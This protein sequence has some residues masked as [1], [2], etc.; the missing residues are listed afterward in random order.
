[1]AISAGFVRN[2]A[3][4]TIL[5]L[6]MEGD[7]YPY[8]ILQD[9]ET[10]FDGQYV[11]KRATLYDMLKR[12]EKKG[13]VSSYF[14][15]ETGGGRRSYYKIEPAGIE[16]LE[17]AKSEYR[18]MNE[19]IRDNSDDLTPSNLVLD[20]NY[21]NYLAQQNAKSALQSETQ[22]DAKISTANHN[23]MAE[24]PK[25]EH[26]LFDPSMYT[27]TEEPIQTEQNNTTT[28]FDLSS[29]EDRDAVN[30]LLADIKEGKRISIITND[31]TEAV[32][33]QLDNEDCDNSIDTQNQEPI[34]DIQQETLIE[35]VPFVEKT[36][37]VNEIIAEEVINYTQPSVSLE[38]EQEATATQ[39]EEVACA[40]TLEAETA[41][42]AEETSNNT[43]INVERVLAEKEIIAQKFQDTLRIF[44]VQEDWHYNIEKGV[45]EAPTP[46]LPPE[47]EDISTLQDTNAEQ[48]ESTQADSEPIQNA[49]NASFNINEDHDAQFK[50]KTY[51]KAQPME[52]L[53]QNMLRE[54]Y[55]IR[56]YNSATMNHNEPKN[57]LIVK[58]LRDSSLLTFLF[59]VIESIL[60]YILRDYFAYDIATLV[61]IVFTSLTIPAVFAFIGLAYPNKKTKADFKWSNAGITCGLIFFI[62]LA[63]CTIINVAMPNVG[64]NFALSKF[65]TPYIYSLC[66]PFGFAMFAILFKSNNYH[67]K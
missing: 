58:L 33:N 41:D 65:Y 27:P 3:K 44:G 7:S 35:S 46:E 12:F 51:P 47:E 19:V 62:T 4:V 21:L 67:T 49:T 22:L 16:F 15:E 53:K 48:L 39:T 10:S 63:L 20:H 50:P 8:K 36:E 6:L 24:Q 11:I 23:T 57:L 64:I 40:D 28:V 18:V 61:E 1:M 34:A 45:Y 32:A 14:G 31:T 26:L 55:R 25:S 29:D 54:G 66:I 42:N 52:Q 17:K 5:N 38:Q 60:I 59:L 9:L 2:H 13:F 30:A 56:E 43:L 37:Q